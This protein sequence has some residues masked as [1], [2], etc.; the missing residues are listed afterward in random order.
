MAEAIGEEQKNRLAQRLSMAT[1]NRDDHGQALSKTQH[2]LECPK[3]SAQQL[4]EL[5]HALEDERVIVPIRVEEDPRVTGV[6]A[7][8]LGHDPAGPAI[9][10]FSSSAS[11]SDFDPSSRPMGLPFKR[12]ALVALVESAGRVVLDPQGADIV[13][14]RSAT[15]ALAQGDHWLPA[16]KDRDLKNLLLEQAS[17]EFSPVSDLHVEYAGQEICRIILEIDA[18]KVRRNEGDLT[19]SE[20]REKVQGVIEGLSALPRLRA[21]TDQIQWVPRWVGM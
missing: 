6:H 13:I 11:L 20:L 18:S 4:E 10:A 5:V 17:R 7:G 15:A 16:W 19:R 3:G 9:A 2:A 21:V 12:V 1:Q 8:E 14:P